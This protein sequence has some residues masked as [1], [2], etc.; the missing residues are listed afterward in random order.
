MRIPLSSY[1]GQPQ[2]VDH[3]AEII[4]TTTTEF[5]AQCLDPPTLEFSKA[6]AFGSLVKARDDENDV[7]VYAVVYF[8]TTS[9]IDSVHRAR[10]IGLSLQQLREEQP[11]V[12]EMLKT[13][14]RAAIVGYRDKRQTHQYL[15]PQPPSI[16]QAI[17]RCSK[18]EIARFSK[19]LRFL[20]TL[21]QLSGAP[22]DELVGATIRAC[23]E[24]H[25][26]SR[27]WLVEAGREI[28]LL[29]KD[30]YDRLGALLQRIRP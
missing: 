11:Q 21:F 1:G 29:L 15:P 18:Q 6:P 23:Y 26:R 12:F 5:L 27:E 7:D 16:H 2:Q 22:S 3:I 13:E 8:A 28:S 19:D 24:A 10:A 25:G 20:R 9:P 17:H 4:E 30:D 14:F